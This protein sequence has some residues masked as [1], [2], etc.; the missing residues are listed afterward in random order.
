MPTYDTSENSIQDG[1]PVELY[2]FTSGSLTLFRYT[3]AQRQITS[4]TNLGLSEDYLPL[5]GLTRTSPDQS[6]ELKRSAITVSVPRDADIA[7]MFVSFLP[8]K[9]IK[10]T[11]F[12]QH[13]GNPNDF[14]RYWSGRVTQ[15]AWK[16]SMAEIECQPTLMRLQ[17]MGLRRNF[18]SGCQHVLYDGIGCRVLAAG[19]ETDVLIS[20]VATTV[21]TGSGEIAASPEADWFEAGFAER[22]NGEIRYVITQSSDTVTVLF[23]FTNLAPGETVSLFAG[24]KH[25]IETCATKFN[26]AEN[27]L[28]DNYFGFHVNPKKNPYV[29]GLN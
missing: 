22:D 5:D 9:R 28:A 29:T 12:R 1:K 6:K 26:T 24:C 16:E 21:L 3:S 17:R 13:D 10:L 7:N 14:V 19:F 27:P 23:P 15:V 4:N 8:P 18:G 11:I 20:D 2:K 25:D